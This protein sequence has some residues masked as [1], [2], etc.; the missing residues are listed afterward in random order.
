MPGLS[1]TALHL[2]LRPPSWQVDT[3]RGETRK[4]PGSSGCSSRQWVEI[5]RVSHAASWCSLNAGCGETLQSRRPLHASRGI[6]VP[7]YG[8]TLLKD[9]DHTIRQKAYSVYRQRLLVSQD[10]L[11]M[12]MVTICTSLTFPL[13]TTDANTCWLSTALS[14]RYSSSEEPIIRLP[15]VAKGS[16]EQL[17]MR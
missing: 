1:E 13:R 16:N 15:G 2:K 5:G 9:F 12:L 4:A 14:P 8:G 7:P 10:F 17:A 3:S 6:E 11:S